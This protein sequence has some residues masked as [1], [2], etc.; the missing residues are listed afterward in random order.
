[1]RDVSRGME[2]I[3]HADPPSSVRHVIGFADTWFGPNW[4]TSNTYVRGIVICFQFACN[5]QDEVEPPS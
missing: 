1:M 4:V 3:L 2:A 5:L